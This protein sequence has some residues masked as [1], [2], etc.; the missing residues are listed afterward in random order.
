MI[1]ILLTVCYGIVFHGPIYSLFLNFFNG[2]WHINYF[3][4]ITG[5]P[6]H[7]QGMSYGLTYFLQIL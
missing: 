2:D 7:N 6:E 1:N 5:I 3:K 4:K